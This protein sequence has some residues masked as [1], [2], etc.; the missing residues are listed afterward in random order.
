MAG[1][2]LEQ[3]V[4]QLKRWLQRL[5]DVQEASRA[6]NPLPPTPEDGQLPTLA[7]PLKFLLGRLSALRTGRKGPTQ[8]KNRLRNLLTMADG[9][10]RRCEQIGRAHARLR[11]VPPKS[12]M[13]ESAVN[14]ADICQLEYDLHVAEAT[15]EIF[16]MSLELG[17]RTEANEKRLIAQQRR[18]AKLHLERLNII[19][20]PS[21]YPTGAVPQEVLDERDMWAEA[22][23]TGKRVQRQ[24][25]S[26]DEVATD[27]LDK[28]ADLVVLYT[29]I[30]DNGVT[31]PLRW[32]TE[33]GI[34]PA[35]SHY[36]NGRDEGSAWSWTSSMEALLAL[37]RRRHVF[38]A[39]STH[40]GEDKL[41]A[42]A[43]EE[44]RGD[45]RDATL[46]L[47]PRH[48]WIRG[49]DGEPVRAAVR[50]AASSLGRAVLLSELAEG[51][52]E[53]PDAVI[54]ECTGMLRAIY[55]VGKGAFVGGTLVSAMGHNVCEP[56][57]WG[58]PTWAGPNHHANIVEWEEV[59]VAM[60]PHLRAVEK[61][62]LVAVFREWFERVDSGAIERERPAVRAALDA[63]L[64]GLAQQSPSRVQSI[65][66]S[67]WR[68]ASRVTKD[69]CSDCESTPETC[70][71]W[72]DFQRFRMADEARVRWFI[73][74]F[75]RF[76]LECR[77]ES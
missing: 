41:L 7:G 31:D 70:R 37:G 26:P 6:G 35:A 67:V 29:M 73:P 30:R 11:A 21:I 61:S 27:W 76:V 51:D 71:H 38:T 75:A 47:V 52:G 66:T 40:P 14:S 64:G 77:E 10:E 23:V 39:G 17:P 72:S 46:V 53:D 22:A 55:G 15:V 28:S 1:T 62:E 45:R 4:Q 2:P 34:R 32:F 65:P 74:G 54:V 8:R 19:A 69:P 63:Y 43:F 44:A 60:K 12:A 42:D 3:D 5:A 48:W 13:G 49:M 9:L 50:A 24:R 36:D 16:A 56:L 57:V 18:A 68:C 58:I 25:A 59:Q 20:D 33:S